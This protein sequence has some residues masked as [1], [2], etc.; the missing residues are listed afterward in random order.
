MLSKQKYLEIIKE[1]TLTAVD[2]IL[3]NDNKILVGWRNNNPAKNTWFTPG[4]RTYKNETQ[5]EAV[6]RVAK[7]ELN[8]EI[9]IDNVKL[10]GVYDHIYK[11]NFQNNDFGTHYVVTAYLCELTK[12]EK[13]KIKKDDQHQLIKWIDLNEL[14]DYNNLHQN[15]K[16]YIPQIKKLL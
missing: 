7:S 3:I 2:L 11:N 5:M 4:V 12:T 9:N 15:V 8:L 10:L 13:N 14:E 6:K 16:N 1:T